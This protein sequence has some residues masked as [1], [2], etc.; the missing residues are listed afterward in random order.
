MDDLIFVQEFIPD[1]DK[2]VYFIINIYGG[3]SSVLPLV[4]C[5]FVISTVKDEQ[6]LT[7]AD[8]KNLVAICKAHVGALRKMGQIRLSSDVSILHLM[9]IIRTISS[10]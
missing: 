9:L 7:T 6:T 8:K 5:N 1:Y 3:I 4:K 2:I 10:Y